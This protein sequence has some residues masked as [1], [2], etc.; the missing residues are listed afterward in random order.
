[1]AQPTRAKNRLMACILAGLLVGSLLFVIGAGK[2]VPLM[3][4]DTTVLAYVGSIG[5]SLWRMN[6]SETKL[7]A[8]TEDPGRAVA[9]ILL[10]AASMISLIAV[11]IIIVQASNSQGLEKAGLIALGLVSVIASWVTVHTTYMIKYAGLYYGDPEGGISFDQPQPP[12]YSDFAYMA[13]TVGLTFQVA[14]T[15]PQNSTVRATILKQALLSYLFGAVI[16]GTVINTIANLG[17]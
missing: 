7:H 1:M 2:F 10:I 15:T 12:R 14:D 8:K 4:W 16:I 3:A 13:F 17:N 6:P 9:D 11:G 5:F